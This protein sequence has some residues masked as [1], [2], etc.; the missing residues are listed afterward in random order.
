MSLE[1]D[2][3]VVLI[4]DD[5]R[6]NSAPKVVRCT[7]NSSIASADGRMPAL[8]NRELRVSMPFTR[9]LLLLS[10]WPATDSVESLRPA[11]LVAGDDPIPMGTAPAEICAS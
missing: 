7:R 10:R 2:R 8:P 4:T 1:P 11:Q 6:P 3:M 9:K 5:E